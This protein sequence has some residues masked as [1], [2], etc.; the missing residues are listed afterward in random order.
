[1]NKKSSL[2]PLDIF[3][4]NDM[5]SRREFVYKFAVTAFS[6]AVPAFLVSCGS[7]SDSDPQYAISFE[8]TF[9]K[10]MNIESV[11]N[12]ISITPAGVDMANAEITWSE[13]N[14]VLYYKA[15]VSSGGN[16]NVTVAGSAESA[17]GNML[18]GNGDGTGGDAYS[19]SLP[20]V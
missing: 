16:F 3:T 14:T 6:V 15:G 10:A 4:N 18:D 5:C 20:A 11:E 7:N 1:M 12:A 2:S 17:G 9:S 19:F 8:L 13:G